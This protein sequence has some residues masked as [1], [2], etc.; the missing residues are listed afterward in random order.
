MVEHNNQYLPGRSHA[1]QPTQWNQHKAV[2]STQYG[3][4]FEHNEP[5]NGIDLLGILFRILQYRWLICIFAVIGI[6]SAL[7]ITMMQTPKYQATSQLEVLTPSVKVFQD[8]EVTS[9]TGDMRAFLTAR[10]K[11]LSRITAERVV[12]ALQLSEKEDFLFPRP[13]VS[14]F[15]LL[16]KAFNISGSNKAEGLSAE[17]RN[18]IAVS[19]TRSNVSVQLIAN[20]SIL[21]ITFHDQNPEYARNIA[22]QFAQSF[23]DQR[24]DQGSQTSVQAR[25]FIQEQVLLIKEKLQIS[26]QALVDYAKFA[27]IT[28]TGDEQSLIGASLSEIN[29]ALSEA[30]Q[31][32]LDY[33]RIVKQINAGSG[34]S[35]EQV[36]SSEGLNKLRTTLSQLK[37]EYQQKLTLFK[38]GFPEMQQLQSQINELQN[39]LNLGTKVITDSI[40]LKHDE[41]LEKVSDLRKK[42]NELEGEQAVYQDKKIQ[43]TMLKREVDSNRTQYDSLISKLNEV[44]VGSELRTQN[45]AIIDLATVPRSPYSPRLSINIAIG[46][47]ALLGLAGVVIYILEIINNTFSNPEQVEKELGLSILGIIPAINPKELVT[48][49]A[50]PKSS[51]SES[52]RS[53]RTSLQFSGVDGHPKTMLITSSEP[54]EG[55]STTAVK[56]AEDFATLGARVL[57]I[58]CD[59][60]KPNIHRLFNIDNAL[61]LSN[62]LTSTIRKEDMSRVIK[63]GTHKNISIIT[64]GTIPPNPADLLSSARM[65]LMISQ[66]S[67]RYDLVILDG[68]PV[69]GLSDAPILSRLTEATL[70]IVSANKAT[71]KSAKMALKRLHAAGSNVIGVVMTMFTVG[72]FDEN[73]NYRYLSYDYYTDGNEIPKIKTVAAANEMNDNEKSWSVVANLNGIRRYF[74]YLINRIKSK[75]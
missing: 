48:M 50:D 64:A 56:L 11:I 74:D 63:K 70:M 4:G 71:R 58:D 35:I 22:N 65:G 28:V 55:K 67:S 2:S 72:K 18:N 40:K 41:T 69:I 17:D 52:Y 1:A 15:N 57:I 21:K 27:G 47:I 6:V 20:T 14:P 24:V 43:Y 59:M 38:P 5:D 51:L 3:Y 49:L 16:Y 25:D 53:L 36:L 9:E 29:K 61:G 33:G 31:E 10:E 66:L 32:S 75:S 26:E 46:L 13:D 12:F 7:I 23:I 37:S 44:A 60:R 19:R 73:Y 30:V 39:Q 42:I 8:I 54:G 68:P 62:L 45:A 34:P